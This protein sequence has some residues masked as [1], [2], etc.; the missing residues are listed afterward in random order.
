[1]PKLDPSVAAEFIRLGGRLSDAVLFDIPHEPVFCP[2]SGGNWRILD[3]GTL[4]DMQATN[5]AY[6]DTITSIDTIGHLGIGYQL[7]KLSD[8][9]EALNTVINAW[10]KAFPWSKFEMAESE[11]ER[12]QLITD[13]DQVIKNLD[14]LLDRCVWNVYPDQ[15]E[16]I[17]ELNEI[18]GG[19]LSL[20]RAGKHDGVVISTVKKQSA[21]LFLQKKKGRASLH[22]L[23]K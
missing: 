18:S 7:T 8:V 15:Y 16:Y 1:M 4:A 23:K 5:K 6:E 19:A 9:N 3:A 12:L 22:I 13:H 17:A 20:P 10:Y 21:S 14:R 2:I 11:M